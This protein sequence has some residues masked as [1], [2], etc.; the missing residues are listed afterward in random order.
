MDSAHKIK[1][2]NWLAPLG[3]A[4][5][6]VFGMLAMNIGFGLGWASYRACRSDAILVG[7]VLGL[8]GLICVAA[9]GWLLAAWNSAQDIR[10]RANEHREGQT[11]E[12]WKWRPDWAAG[13]VQSTGKTALTGA[14]LK[15]GLWSAFS[16]GLCYLVF[17]PELGILRLALL[18]VPLF[19]VW[20]VVQAF[21]ATLRWRRFGESW[22]R[23]PS[24]PGFVGGD[25]S[26]A[27]ETPVKIRPLDGFHVKLLCIR[28]ASDGRSS[29]LMPE[30]VLWKDEKV[31]VR[32]LLD[33]GSR[34]S[35]IPVYFT[36]PRDCSPT[37]DIAMTLGRILW[38]LEV[39]A[40][41]PGLSYF[42]GFE[43]PVFLSCHPQSL[44]STPDPT[45]PYQAPTSV[46]RG[47]DS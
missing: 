23:M 27:I 33:D 18:V 9:G 2:H 6:L 12:S 38:R 31:L 20:Q 1:L 7:I 40:R 8:V 21:S 11:P 22:F 32:E 30:K 44:V 24:V 37:D 3:T 17:N 28:Q 14:W 41:L 10:R 16:C 39:R 35:A 13:R 36:I 46:S 15:V 25:L 34:Q 5:R 26:G 4:G 45:L 47:S 29:S 43:V 19:A 42:A